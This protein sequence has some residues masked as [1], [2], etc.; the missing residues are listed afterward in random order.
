M[1]LLDT[2]IW[3]KWVLDENQLP[4]PVRTQVAGH[5]ENGL[6]VSVI[7]CWEVAKLVELKRLNFEMDIRD[8]IDHALSYPG[9]RLLEL[10]TRI[11]VESTRLPGE[12]HR[13]PADQLIVATARVHDCP[14][15]TLDRKILK[16]DHVKL[17]R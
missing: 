15:L 14:L 3:V 7:S 6:G 2:H 16:Y 1:I 9:I 8:W 4:K 13:D 10:S 5:E 12:F 17:L 11:A